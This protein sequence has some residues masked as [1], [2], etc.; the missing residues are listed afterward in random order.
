[1]LHLNP[2]L[3]TKRLRRIEFFVLRLQDGKA[4]KRDS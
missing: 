4:C 1:V 2:Y 3:N